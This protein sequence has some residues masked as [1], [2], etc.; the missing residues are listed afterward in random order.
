MGGGPCAPLVEA[1]V[2]KYIALSPE[3]LEE[4]KDD[5]ESYA[6]FGCVVWTSHI[7]VSFRGGSIFG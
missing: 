2:A 1:I 6:R 7:N 3:E 5:P 4:W